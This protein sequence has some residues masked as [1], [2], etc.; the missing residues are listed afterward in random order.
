M[1][2]TDRFVATLLALT[3]MFFLLFA[4]AVVVRSS[5]MATPK[6]S[7]LLIKL[8]MCV[9][10]LVSS[11]AMRASFQVSIV[12]A[13]QPLLMTFS[14]SLT[15]PAFVMSITSFAILRVSSSPPP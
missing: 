10:V 4:Y 13:P 3:L 14:T 8:T 1:H 15:M 9:V 5:A 12:F 11:P 7:V 2:E 6:F